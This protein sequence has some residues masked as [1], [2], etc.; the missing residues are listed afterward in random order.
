MCPE[1][2][3]FPFAS[4]DRPEVLAARGTA[5]SEL[6]Q[7]FQV[8]AK[9]AMVT[10]CPPGIDANRLSITMIGP[11]TR[12]AFRDQWGRGN[13]LHGEG[14]FWDEFTQIPYYQQMEDR[15]EAA[16]WHGEALI[17]MGIG[18]ADL[19]KGYVARD[20][21]E[22]GPTLEAAEF[23]GHVVQMMNICLETWAHV[24]GAHHICIFDP[25]FSSVERLL[26]EG[27]RYVSSIKELGIE[28]GP[29]FYSYCTR[30]VSTNAPALDFVFSPVDLAELG[31]ANDPYQLISKDGLVPQEAIEAAQSMA[32]SRGLME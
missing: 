32:R 11:R 25:N 6:R 12:S 17:A 7:T 1:P 27:F 9:A 3:E 23:K 4:E 20:F 18:E 31:L 5:W 2:S 15:F 29:A 24:V 10:A 21:V 28:L 30:P 14:F 16:I 13:S 8:R 26:D 22:R 19:E